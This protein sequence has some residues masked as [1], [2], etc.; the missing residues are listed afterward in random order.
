MTQQEITKLRVIN[1]AIDKVITIREAAELL[2]LSERQV[3]RLKGGVIK[4]GPAFIIHKN[5]GRK[6]EHAIPNK[7]Q[8]KIVELKKTKYQEANFA[9]FKDLLEEHEDICVS[10][11]SVYRILTQAGVT[12][13]KKQRKRK[14]HHRRKRKPQEGMMVQIDASPH[15][16]IIGESAFSLHGSID[17]ATG[18]ITAL[19]FTENECLEGYFQIMRYMIAEYGAPMSIY[20]DRH[21][22]FI[23]PKDGKLSIDEQLQGKHV[24]LTQF[25]RAMEELGVNIIKAKSAQG[26]GRIERLWE[27]LQSRLPVEFKIRGINTLEEANAFL[28]EFVNCYNKKFAVEPE[29]PESAFRKVNKGMDLDTI[30]CIKEERT[31]INGSAF[32][33][34]GQYYQLM[35]SQKHAPLLPKA[36]ITVLD[37]SEKGIRGLYD[38]EVYETIPLEERPKN[39]QIL[40]EKS[41]AKKARKT[42][43]PA[44]HPWRNAQKKP[45]PIHE[46]PD[47][48][49]LKMLDELFSSTRAWA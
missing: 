9:H 4:Q 45:K 28:S 1:Q 16:W 3:I 12:S 40:K 20:C 48:E 36:K 10:Y 37:S 15:T 25:G 17:D 47:S 44:N 41:K 49:I 2:D 35:K 21:T 32:S 43:V 18:K 31:V 33:Y 26:K 8:E 46:E 6:P 14:A 5:R 13:P 22:I 7:E 23:S 11:P 34:Q 38:G 39:E 29:K 27:T 42:V 30:L 24:N 19:F